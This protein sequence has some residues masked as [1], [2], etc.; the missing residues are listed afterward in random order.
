MVQLFL[1]FVDGTGEQLTAFVFCQER[2]MHEDDQQT[3][4]PRVVDPI[5]DEGVWAIVDD[6]CNS[7]C[8]G[9]LWRSTP[10]TK[11]ITNI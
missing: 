3:Q 6:G 7:C 9:E 5:L 8:H 2:P 1:D 4:T 11:F 10:K